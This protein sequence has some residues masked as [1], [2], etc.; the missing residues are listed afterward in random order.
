[1]SISRKISFII[2]L[3]ITVI[4][5]FLVTVKVHLQSA[6]PSKLDCVQTKNNISSSW[7]SSTTTK[8]LRI[9]T[10]TDSKIKQIM[11]LISQGVSHVNFTNLNETTSA[12]RSKATIVN[13][14][15]SYCVGDTITV[16]VEMF[17]YLGEKKAYGGDFLRARIYS[18]NLGAAASGT[19]EDFDNGTYNVH[20]TLFWEGRVTISIILMHPSEG[21][22]VLWKSR[23]NRYK[24]VKFVGKFLNRNQEV[25]TECGFVLATEKEKCEYMD[26]RYGE[27]F[28]CI[29]PPGLAC[30]AMVS[31]KSENTPYT[32]LTKEQKNLFTRSNIGE[33]IPKPAESVIVLHCTRHFLKE[34]EKCKTGMSPPFPSGYFLN[35]QWFPIYCNLTSYDPLK[36][37][38]KCL[39]GKMIYLMGDSTSRQWIEYLPRVIKTL[40]AF[41]NHETSW[42]RKILAI[43]QTNNIQVQWK[44]HGHPFV[45]M[46]FFNMRDHTYIT[47]EIDRL[48]GSAYTIIVITV[49]Q[50]FR[51]FPLDLFIRRVFSIRKAIEN[52]FL[53]SPETKVIIKSENTREINLD[54][55][56]FSDFHGYVQYL[57]VKEI[58][59]GLNVGVIDAWDMTTAY[60]S[61]NVHPPD[62][63]IKNQIN[64]FLSY[65]C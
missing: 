14:K 46:S 52:L 6:K 47:D 32:H 44:K 59:R 26:T 55:E 21:V 15:P 65:I 62:T 42:H 7:R 29:R 49:G 3:S 18:P 5:I 22:S 64:L 37:I 36:N 10:T 11:T 20:F 25:H 35:D 23:S 13:Y 30:E 39:A 48:L 33:E 53:R 61:Y 28:Y 40:K 1:M 34:T 60:G 16:Q 9:L 17:N 63:V 45:T 56:R 58:F 2:I 24:Y 38:E 57:V 51:P 27:S 8:P 50:H 41:D 54:V 43:D 31:M 4:C 12:R 19:I